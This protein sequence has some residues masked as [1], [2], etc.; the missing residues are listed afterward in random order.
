VTAL[1][2]QCATLGVGFEVLDLR[3]RFRELVE[4]PFARAYLGGRTPNPCAGCNARVKFGLL[5]DAARQRGATRL[6]TGHYVRMVEH[7]RHGRVP[8]MGADPAKDQS[9]FLAMVPADRLAAEGQA[10]VP[11]LETVFEGLADFL[12][13]H[14]EPDVLDALIHKD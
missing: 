4:E 11:T 8:A 5:L 3:E 10:Y 9:Y 6:A 1:A 7:P 13:R 2:A 12:E 14:V